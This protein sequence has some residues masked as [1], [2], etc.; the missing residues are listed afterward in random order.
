MIFG[1][2]T[3]VVVACAVDEVVVVTG[4]VVVGTMMRWNTRAS[5]FP[6]T[7]GKNIDPTWSVLVIAYTP[8]SDD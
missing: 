3:V 8:L 1:V 2:P 6:S 4:N 7:A 5:S